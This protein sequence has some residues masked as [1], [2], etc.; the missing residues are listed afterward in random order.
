MRGSRRRF[1]RLLA[2]GSAVA[3]ATP[4]VLARAAAPKRPVRRD[5]VTAPRAP[6]TE[7]P[8]AVAEELRR[9]RASLAESLKK[10]RDFPLPPGS[11]PAGRF[12]PLGPR[13]KDA[14]P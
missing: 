6:A 7:L 13:R 3:A 14:R 8:P 12:V 1:L 4:A 2:A 5:T 9:Q 10:V 11:E